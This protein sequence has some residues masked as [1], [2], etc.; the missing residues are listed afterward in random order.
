MREMMAFVLAVVFVAV[1]ELP[2]HPGPRVWVGSSAGRLVTYTSDNDLAPSFFTPSRLFKGELEEGFP[3]TGIYYTDFP[4]F[5]V[6]TV[7]PGISPG[8]VFGFDIAGPL[9]MYHQPAQAFRTTAELFGPPNPGPVPQLG[10]SL[11]SELRQT[12]SGPVAGFN[13]FQHNA[14]GDHAHLFFVLFG[15]GTGASNGPSGIYA[16]PMTLRSGGFDPTQTFYI[17]LGKGYGT[18]SPLFLEALDRASATL[19]APPITGLGPVKPRFSPG[20]T[21]LAPEPSSATLVLT[22]LYALMIRR[23]TQQPPPGSFRGI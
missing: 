1:T 15:N 22:G 3:G 17:L 7:N 11:D 10:V 14:I 23:R 6:K 8:T 2:A 13:F 9:L 16:L 21:S 20:Q 12:G 5:Q 18:Q 4:G 19:V